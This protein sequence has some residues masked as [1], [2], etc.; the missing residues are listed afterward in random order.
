M[1]SNQRLSPLWVLLPALA[2]LGLW[3][4]WVAASLP[5]SVD[6]AYYFAWSSTPDW[7]YWTKPP[8]IAWAIGAADAVCGPAAAC[9]RSVGVLS[10]SLSSWLVYVLARRMQLDARLALAAALG[11]ATLPLTTF[12]GLV[13]STDALLLLCWVL[14]MLCLWQAIQ[15]P[16][17]LVPWLGLGLFA[18]LGLLAKYSM[19]VLAPCVALVLLH[20]DWR[21]HWRTPGPYLAAL[22]AL[23][24]FAP[25]LW[26]NLTHGMPTLHHT[27][28]ISRGEAYS[29]KPGSM[30]G[31]LGEQWVVGNVVLASA[32]VI[33]LL[34]SRWWREPLSWFWAC[35]SVPMLAVI[36][37]QALLSR[38]NANWA[39][40]AHVAMTLV[41][42]SVLWQGRRHVWMAVALAFNLLFAILLYHGQTL[43]REP[44]GLSA[45]WRTDPY[46]ALRNW[47]G[48]H[49]QTQAL[50]AEAGQRETWRVA[51]DDRAVLAQLQWGLNL[52]AGAAMGWRRSGV[53]MN[54]FDQR[55]ELN[56][57]RGPVLLLTHAPAEE[58]LR[59]FP[60]ARRVG[61]LRSAL[62]AEEAIV[63]DAWWL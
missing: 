38:A 11:F 37:L 60:Q 53:A 63:L 46:W 43:V 8:L 29:L 55:F 57:T 17:Q 23:A 58:V 62:V 18:G 3:R 33:W 19:V 44:L 20:P 10:F 2:A 27:A 42:V 40:P 4:W 32:F 9:V 51:S 31:F 24:V 54:H 59:Q 52:P 48:V 56:T 35:L 1:A 45:S 14:A 12:Y 7:G 13:A 34:R 41:G 28:D 25:N 5:L 61:V 15:R 26:W 21:R 30:L 39:A 6:E 22:L 49:E 36:A 50:L 16:G 47:P